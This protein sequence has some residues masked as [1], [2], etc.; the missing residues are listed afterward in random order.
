[1][2]DQEITDIAI[3][4]LFKTKGKQQEAFRMLMARYKE[5]LYWHIRKIVLTHDDADDALQNSFIK[6]WQNL[7][8][9]QGNSALFT[10]LYRI[11]TNEALTLL[12]KKKRANLY[13]ISDEDN[14]FGDS[15]QSDPYFDGSALQL[16]LQKAIA[17]LPEKQK[18]IF[19]LKYF[20]EMKYQEIAEITETSVGSLKASYH[21]AAKKIEAYLKANMDE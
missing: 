7:E 19:N 9:F 20:E 8:S 6:I 4:D 17:T 10:W 3:V 16:L 5:R 12:K 1:M 2:V 11:A 18:I 21:H 13:S 14:T 15:L